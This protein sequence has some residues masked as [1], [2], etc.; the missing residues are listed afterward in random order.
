MRPGRGGRLVAAGRG[1]GSRRRAAPGVPLRAYGAGR[2]VLDG[3]WRRVGAPGR[4]AGAWCRLV[5]AGRG[6]GRVVL[7]GSWRRVVAPGRGA[8]SWCR[9][10]APGRGAGS[11]RR[12]VA[13]PG[14]VATHERVVFGGDWTEFGSKATFSTHWRV[15]GA[16]QRV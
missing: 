9:I 1:R 7:D 3:A 10:V 11:W 4:G 15:K 8:G 14:V 16:A 6:A 12:V 13:V 2:V 5:A